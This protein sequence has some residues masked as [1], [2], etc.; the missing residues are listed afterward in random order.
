MS[1]LIG[2]N[3]GTQHSVEFFGT[4]EISASVYEDGVAGPKYRVLL[5]TRHNAKSL[6]QTFTADDGTYSFQ[7]L[8]DPASQYFA[9]ALDYGASQGTPGVSASLVLS[10]MTFSF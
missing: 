8:K 10:P 7:Y 4:N 1:L 3:I 9:V 6:L 2:D 5:F